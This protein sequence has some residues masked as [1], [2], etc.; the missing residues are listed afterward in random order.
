MIINPNICPIHLKS[1]I[2]GFTNTGNGSIFVCSDCLD[3][4][5]T[6]ND[7]YQF[8]PGYGMNLAQEGIIIHRANAIFDISYRSTGC[9]IKIYDIQKRISL[10]MREFH[11]G[12]SYQQ[13]GLIY[14]N[15]QQNLIDLKKFYKIYTKY[16]TSA[17]SF[18]NSF[19]LCM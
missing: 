14:K 13:Y 6:K 1:L 18:K 2:Q 15:G 4:H 12:S 7:T 3:T 9:I 16:N 5:W 10:P 8:H 17:G 11:N 19:R